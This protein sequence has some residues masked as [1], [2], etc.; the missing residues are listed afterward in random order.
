MKN[1]SRKQIGDVTNGNTI[2]YKGHTI[3]VSGIWNN[4]QAVLPDLDGQLLYKEDIPLL[5]LK[6]E[7]SNGTMYNA[8]LYVHNEADYNKKANA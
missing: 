8:T 5:F 2:K 7:V 4:T 6:G 3:T 1:Y